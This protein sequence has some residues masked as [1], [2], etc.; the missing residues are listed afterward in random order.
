MLSHTHTPPV[1]S[2]IFSSWLPSPPQ[3]WWPDTQIVGCTSHGNISLL[4]AA[5]VWT[6]ASDT[7]MRF[8]GTHEPIPMTDEA[9]LVKHREMSLTYLK[10][11]PHR[12]SG[13]DSTHLHK[14]NGHWCLCGGYMDHCHLTNKTCHPIKES[15]QFREPPQNSTT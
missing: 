12:V 7:L 4:C 14:H 1:R 10:A 5:T 2:A 9:K 3:P 11:L 8:Q 15:M 6:A 13:E